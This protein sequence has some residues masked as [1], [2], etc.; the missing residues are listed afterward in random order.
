MRPTPATRAEPSIFYIADIGTIF[1]GP[2][3][4]EPHRHLVRKLQ[5]PLDRLEARLFSYRI[6]ERIGLQVRQAR[7]TQPQRRLEPFERLR[8]IAPLRVDRG[9]LI[10]R[11]IAQCALIFESSASASACRPSLS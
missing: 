3:E 11:G 1:E 6:H 10:R 5:L 9:V 7:I 2:K 4:S 8:P